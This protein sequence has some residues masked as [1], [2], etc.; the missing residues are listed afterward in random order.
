LAEER[1]GEME[2]I[3]DESEPK[4]EDGRKDKLRKLVDWFNSPEAKDLAESMKRADE[5]R[6][7]FLASNPDNGKHGWWVVSGIRH[8]AIVR[9]S[10]A[11]LAVEKAEAAGAV[12]EW[13]APTAR[14]LSEELPDVVSI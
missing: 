6:I 9:T 7:A 2:V 14:F 13:E 3:M 8:N 1:Y 12:G 4:W 5:E 11:V 10:S